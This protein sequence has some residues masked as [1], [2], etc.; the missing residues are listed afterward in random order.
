MKGLVSNNVGTCM[1]LSHTH[2]N[3]ADVR[4][5]FQIQCVGKI[6]KDFARLIQQSELN[7]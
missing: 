7:K 2:S 1:S 6:L 3:A 4:G 5:G